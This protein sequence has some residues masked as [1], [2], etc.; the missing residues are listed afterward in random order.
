MLNCSHETKR[1]NPLQ[2]F[3]L[4]LTE[5]LFERT[6]TAPVHCGSVYSV[7]LCQLGLTMHPLFSTTF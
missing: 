7:S 2:T 6:G 4:L 5:K 1:M 3:T